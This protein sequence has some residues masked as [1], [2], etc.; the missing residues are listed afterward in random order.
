M[1]AC[2]R[3]VGKLLFADAASTDIARADIATLLQPGSNPGLQ[4]VFQNLGALPCW[5]D[6]GA[7]ACHVSTLHVTLD[8]EHISRPCMHPMRF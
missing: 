8:T 6:T 2:A 3:Q 4:R 7:C 1:S 5:V